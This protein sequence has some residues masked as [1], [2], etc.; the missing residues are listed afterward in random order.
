MVLLASLLSDAGDTNIFQANQLA[1]KLLKS[2]PLLYARAVL[3]SLEAAGS[4]YIEL[5]YRLNQQKR[6]E[7]LVEATSSR[8]FAFESQL[9][10][11][12]RDEHLVQFHRFF[13]AYSIDINK[14]PELLWQYALTF[15]SNTVVHQY[16]QT[17]LQWYMHW[18][19]RSG[20]VALLKTVPSNLSRIVTTI[21]HL[22]FIESLIKFI[23]QVIRV[24]FFL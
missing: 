15:P 8:R 2:L 16:A 13:R 3:G 6:D 4:E 9:T 21:G 1:S 24:L 23:C 5:E 22:Y 11:F 18:S 14:V 17:W 10:Q 7:N 19:L 20:A 12:D